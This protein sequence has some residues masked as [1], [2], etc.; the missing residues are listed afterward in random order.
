MTESVSK[1]IHSILFNRFG[2]SNLCK[3][4]KINI[5]NLLTFGFFS[6]AISRKM[7]YDNISRTG[8]QR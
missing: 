3:M 4:L 8:L 6:L 7:V 2:I 1:I 5:D